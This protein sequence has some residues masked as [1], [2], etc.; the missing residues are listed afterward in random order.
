MSIARAITDLQDRVEDAYDSIEDMGGTVPQTKDTY[1]LPT[2]IESIPLGLPI[3][4]LDTLTASGTVVYNEAL[5][6]MRVQSFSYLYDTCDVVDL[7]NLVGYLGTTNPPAVSNTASFG[8]A[9]TNTNPIRISMPKLQSTQTTSVR[10]AFTSKTRLKYIDIRS[11]TG[12]L[13]NSAT[14]SS[15]PRIFGDAPLEFCAWGVSFLNYYEFY[16]CTTL[17][18]LL[19]PNCKDGIGEHALEG[20]SNLEKLMIHAPWYSDGKIYGTSGLTKLKHVIVTRRDSGTIIGGTYNDRIFNS[21]FPYMETLEVIV[22]FNSQT[23]SWL[24]GV[25]MGNTVLKNAIFRTYYGIDTRLKSCTNLQ[26]VDI[27]HP[28]A[29]DYIINFSSGYDVLNGCQSLRRVNVHDKIRYV[30]SEYSGTWTGVSN[31][32]IWFYGTTSETTGYYG[33]IFVNNWKSF[34]SNS[35]TGFSHTNVAHFPLRGTKIVWDDNTSAWV[36]VQ[37]DTVD[38]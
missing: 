31:C 8:G 12:T 4:I 23:Y 34:I 30:S 25:V 2:A 13:G 19:L 33:D 20:C 9:F 21:F 32:H 10:S 16:N 18:E 27:Y 15:S 38:D 24:G 26:Q 5:Q 7:P 28:P 36:E 17:K 6:Y 14:S 37:D 29:I 11:L 22:E 35:S 1:H 3:G